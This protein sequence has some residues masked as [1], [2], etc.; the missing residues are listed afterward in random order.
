MHHQHSQARA[1]VHAAPSNGVLQ[2]LPAV[3]L[4]VFLSF[5][6]F[7]MP[8][9]AKAD[10]QPEDQA[11][12]TSII[13]QQLDAFTAEDAERAF[14]FASPSIQAQFGS[15]DIFNRMVQEGYAPVYRAQSAR[16]LEISIIAGRIVQPVLLTGP[17]GALTIAD[18]IME[19]QSDGSWRIAD[20][21]LRPAE[22]QSV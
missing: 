10:V 4:T 2:A 7:F 14:S 8:L 13:Q 16:F 18:Y 5:A 15:A 22:D 17:N 11:A 1:L 12:I 19:R 20:C 3:V 9:S 6:I 21:I